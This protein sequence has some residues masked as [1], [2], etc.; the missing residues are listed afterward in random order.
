MLSCLNS[1][2]GQGV[3]QGAVDV[4]D[5]TM[6]MRVPDPRELTKLLGFDPGRLVQT[7]FGSSGPRMP[8]APCQP[9]TITPADGGGYVIREASHEQFVSCRAIDVSNAGVVLG[10]GSPPVRPADYH[11]WTAPL[12]G[13][14]KAC[15][16]IG[17]PGG[18]NDA[19]EVAATAKMSDGSVHA[20]RW[21]E[22]AFVD[23][24]CFRGNDSGATAINT[25]GLVVGWV[26]VDHSVD[27][28]QLSHR[29]AAWSSDKLNVLE[30][31]GCDWGQAVDVNDAGIVLVVGY[32][33]RQCRA[34]LWNPLA[35]TTEGI[36]GMTGIYPS[37]ITADG[38][39]S[40]DGKGSGR[41][42]GRL[43]SQ[44][45]KAVGAARYTA[46]LPRDS[47]ERRGRRRWRAGSGRLPKAVAQTTS[48]EILWL[49]YFAHH[50]CLPSAINDS[51]VIVGTATTDHGTHALI[52]ARSLP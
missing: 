24:G 17:Q 23:L 7:A 10:D 31:F 46:W 36:G 6:G 22:G 33:G 40:G 48:G 43:P 32:V 11:L 37:A 49:P 34:I 26:C 28:G 12:E 2:D 9:Q 47:N 1:W 35:E 51:S 52:W 14:P 50:N 41:Q 42:D 13:H 15:G 18:I 38:V 20:V 19:G 3:H 29:P 45:G 4:L 5:M 8:Y 16:L 44:A 39:V 30:E 25:A 27:R 21:R